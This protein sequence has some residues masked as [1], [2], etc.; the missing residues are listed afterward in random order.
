VLDERQVALVER[1]DLLLGCGE[2]SKEAVRVVLG[3]GQAEGVVDAG[4]HHEEAVAL[5]GAH[6]LAS[7][8]AV[9]AGIGF[10]VI[11]WRHDGHV[12]SAVMVVVRMR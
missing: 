10:P 11:L 6:A 1:G 5:V 3:A 2:F 9:E 7:R 8:S 4:D 12:I